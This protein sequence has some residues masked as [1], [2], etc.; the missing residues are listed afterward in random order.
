MTMKVGMA[1]RMSTVILLMIRLHA[2]MKN[3]L[4]CCAG[5]RDIKARRAKDAMAPKKPSLLAPG[6]RALEQ[7]PNPKC[8]QEA[9]S[10]RAMR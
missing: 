10:M 3:G 5:R 2:S 1:A 8:W 9:R 4:S 7:L 6:P